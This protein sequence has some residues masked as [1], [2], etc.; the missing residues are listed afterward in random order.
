MSTLT[1]ELCPQSDAVDLNL[2]CPQEIARSGHYG[3]FLQGEWDLI[4][5]YRLGASSSLSTKG[6]NKRAVCPT[7]NLTGIVVNIL[8]VSLDVPVTVK[9]RVFPSTEKKSRICTHARERRRPDPHMPRPHTRS[10]L[11]ARYDGVFHSSIPLG[12]LLL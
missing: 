8:H 4:Y 2:G 7:S 5:I 3:S 6:M 10:A 9:F 11:S 12:S 1:S